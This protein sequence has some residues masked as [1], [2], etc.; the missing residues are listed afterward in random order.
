MIISVLKRGHRE[1]FGFRFDPNVSIHILPL[2]SLRRT[3]LVHGFLMRLQA[4]TACSQRIHQRVAT[5]HALTKAVWTAVVSARAC[6]HINHIASGLRR[7]CGLSQD[8]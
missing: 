8:D 4:F 6:S 2:R 3:P 7:T 1:P 5:G